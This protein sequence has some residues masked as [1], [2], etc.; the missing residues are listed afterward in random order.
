MKELTFETLYAWATARCARSECCRSEMVRK[1]R[2]KGADSDMACQ[3]A[4][5]LEEERYLDDARYARAFVHDRTLYE[6]W[7]R[8]KIQQALMQRG[9]SPSLI[10][11]AL[12][13]IDED[14]YQETLRELLSAK[15]RT[16]RAAT[17]YELR[18][19]LM[20]FATSRGFEAHLIMENLPLA[21]EE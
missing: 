16:T 5:R 20:R 19:K 15:A 1:M 21:D 3:V 11:E 17:T 8:M 7:G 13:T 18:L 14:Q 10:T 9:V 4:D 6:R 2:E 12:Q